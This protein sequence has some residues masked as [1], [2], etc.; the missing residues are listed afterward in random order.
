MIR[1]TNQKQVIMEKE[2]TNEE[3]LVFISEM[4]GQAKSNFAH[5]TSFHFLLW[6]WVTSIANFS[7]YLLDRFDLYDMPFIVWLITIPAAFISLWYGFRKADKSQVVSHLD[8][9]YS[10]MWISITVLIIICLIFMGRIGFNHNPF[11]LL[12]TGL[13][14]FVSGVLMKYKPVMIGGIILWVGAC[15]GLLVSIQDQQLIAGIVVIFGYLIPG[16]ML[17]KEESKRV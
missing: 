15:M 7:H 12:F 3:R 4:I 10:S 9:V 5:R 6:G 14:T 13:G 8:K 11:I 16:Y 17:K 1:T 2:L